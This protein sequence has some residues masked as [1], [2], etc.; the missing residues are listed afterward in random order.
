[1]AVPGMIPFRNLVQMMIKSQVLTLNRLQVMV[2]VSE[3]HVIHD[4]VNYHTFV[5]TAAKAIE[6]MFEP[7]S[8][9]VRSELLEN[10]DL[11][12]SQLL[13]GESSEEFHRC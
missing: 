11:S 6:M 2:I 12:V 1:M 9:R 3:A 13:E 4:M 8:V 10:T 5:P 7:N